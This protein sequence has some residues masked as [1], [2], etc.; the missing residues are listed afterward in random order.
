MTWAVFL[1]VA[2]RSKFFKNEVHGSERQKCTLIVTHIFPC[3]KQC[4]SLCM[5][6]SLAL[7]QCDDNQII[8]SGLVLVP[9][10]FKLAKLLKLGLS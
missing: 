5:S 8:S 6:V 1:N 7:N 10:S 2:D 4:L 9:Q 3:L